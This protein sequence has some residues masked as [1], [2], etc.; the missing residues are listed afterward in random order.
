LL[1]GALA[2]APSIL[3]GTPLLFRPAAVALPSVAV[4][5]RAGVTLATVLSGTTVAAGAPV[6]A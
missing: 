5:R 3:A 1:V 6:A 4:R 2:A